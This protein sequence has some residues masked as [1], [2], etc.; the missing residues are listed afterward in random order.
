MQL[1]SIPIDLYVLVCTDGDVM[2]IKL[3]RNSRR[4]RGE[5]V[6]RMWQTKNFGDPYYLGFVIYK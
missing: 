5:G 2:Q 3:K 6:S 4:Q 1:Y